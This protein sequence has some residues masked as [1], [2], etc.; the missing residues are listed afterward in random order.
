MCATAPDKVGMGRV[1]VATGVWDGGRS[2]TRFYASFSP[3]TAL[4]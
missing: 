4:K 3:A 2:S 1:L